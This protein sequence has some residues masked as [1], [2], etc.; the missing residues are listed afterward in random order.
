MP[1]LAEHHKGA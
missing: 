1:A